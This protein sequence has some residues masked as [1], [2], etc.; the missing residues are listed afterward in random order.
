MQSIS[1]LVQMLGRGM[2]SEDDFCYC[3]VLDSQFMDNLKRRWWHLIPAS[4]KASIDWYE[5]RPIDADME[6]ARVI[7]IRRKR[8]EVSG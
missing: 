5:S 3:Y 4:I 1:T 8:G 2:R 6:Q 7:R